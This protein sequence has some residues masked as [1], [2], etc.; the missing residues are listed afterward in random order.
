[1]SFN[2]SSSRIVIVIRSVAAIKAPKH[3]I[4]SD[5]LAYDRPKRGHLNLAKSG[6]YNLARTSKCQSHFQMSGSRLNTDVGVE[7]GSGCGC[8]AV[9]YIYL[10]GV[11]STEP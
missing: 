5:L 9:L 7:V 2:L 6:H 11:F 4:P 3:W 1:M 8:F 10:E